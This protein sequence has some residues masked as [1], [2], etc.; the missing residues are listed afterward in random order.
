MDNLADTLLPQ[1]SLVCA[2]IAQAVRDC[3]KPNSQEG[4]EALRW[5]GS[6]EALEWCEAWE[7]DLERIRRVVDSNAVQCNRMM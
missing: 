7:I 5:L 1:R 2:I 4:K 6:R 3:C